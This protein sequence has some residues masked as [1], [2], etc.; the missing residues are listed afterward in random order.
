MRP[1]GDCRKFA[2]FH[3]EAEYFWHIRIHGS[4][5]IS[6]HMKYQKAERI[7]YKTAVNDTI[8]DFGFS[9]CRLHKQSS[10]NNWVIIWK[11]R[12]SLL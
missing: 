4:S 8:A 3:L 1:S 11:D 12:E 9:Q 2:F 6:F 10:N 7:I 5:I